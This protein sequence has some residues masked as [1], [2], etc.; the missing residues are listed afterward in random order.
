MRL[1]APV[2]SITQHDDHVVVEADGVS[3]SARHA[4]VTVPPALA[5]EIAFDPALPDDRLTLYRKAVAGSREQ[6]AR[7]LR[8][9]VLAR[10]RLQRPD[11]RSPGSAAEVTHRRVARDGTPGV[12]ASFT[13]GPVATHF[14]AL[15][16]AERR[17]AVLDALTAR[18][19]PRAASPV[20][21][22]ETAWW[23]EEWTRGC[24]MAHLPPGILTRYGPLLQSRSG[25]CTGPEPRPRPR[26]TA[27]STA[28]C[29]PAS[30]PRPRSST[31][32]LI[33]PRTDASPGGRMPLFRRRAE[34]Q[35]GPTGVPGLA[36]LAASLGLQPVAPE[37][38]FDGHLEDK[39]HETTRILY[40]EPR[41]WTTITHVVVGATTFSDA[42]RGTVAG[43]T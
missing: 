26:R 31:A 20:E 25:A 27:R 32:S 43:H 37:R 11:R 3:V 13:F 18:L 33:Y 6:D 38:L 8:R 35:G 5:L 40:G 9:A 42:Y 17:Q 1:N 28:P 2:R 14:D 21:F 23:S 30:A 10:R 19:G 15:D 29:A 7:G 41:S 12:I 16:P 34:V 39:V 4:V 24:S 36:D 22:I